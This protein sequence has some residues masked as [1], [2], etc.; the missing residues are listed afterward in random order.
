MP[1]VRISLRE[2]FKIH[3]ND[4]YHKEGGD[5]A[6]IPRSAINGH[7]RRHD[8]HGGSN[9]FTRM[10]NCR[11]ALAALDRRGWDVRTVVSFAYN[12]V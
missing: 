9:G 1:P 12:C 4:V 10:A 7:M 11:K 8:I 2:I 5:T 3:D 6:L